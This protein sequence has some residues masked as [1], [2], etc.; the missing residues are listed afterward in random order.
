MGNRTDAAFDS[1]RSAAIIFNFVVLIFFPAWYRVVLN[2]IVCF[3]W[4]AKGIGQKDVVWE[5][6]MLDRLRSC[7]A[8]GF[9]T[10]FHCADMIIYW[11]DE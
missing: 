5:L 7:H 1:T 6:I 4:K 9:A 10:K 11:L 8:R 3:I 2:G